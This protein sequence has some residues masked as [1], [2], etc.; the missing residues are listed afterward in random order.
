MMAAY[1]GA[2]ALVMGYLVTISIVGQKIEYRETFARF[3]PLGNG[4][5]R[6]TT[7]YWTQADMNSRLVEFGGTI[8]FNR[9]L[10]IAI[11][12]AVPRRHRVA[13]L[14]DRARTVEAPIAQ[15]RETRSTRRPRRRDRAVAGRR[16]GHRAGSPAVAPGPV[17]DPAADRGAPGADQPRSHRP[18][19]VRHRQHRGQPVARPVDLWDVRASNPGGNNFQPPHHFH[20]LPD[21]DRGL[22]RR[23]ARV[24]RARPKAQRDLGFDVRSPAG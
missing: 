6:E 4:A 11:G 21:H 3:D 22:L 16:P 1:I 13:L 19:P 5:L 12:L 20:G 14:D 7:R 17:H 9:V 2:V 8:L 10:A 24:A 23:R 15:A 18:V